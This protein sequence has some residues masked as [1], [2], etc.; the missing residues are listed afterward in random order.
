MVDCVL[1]GRRVLG[2]LLLYRDSRILLSAEIT[3]L[4]AAA[5]VHIVVLLTRL[6]LVSRCAMLADNIFDVN[7]PQ[8]CSWLRPG[9]FGNRSCLRKD[10]C[11]LCW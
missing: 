9:W 3:A 8:W 4:G 2:V 5:F 11:F 7:V 6:G 10:A 1:L